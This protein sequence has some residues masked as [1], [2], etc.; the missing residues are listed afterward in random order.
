[1][2]FLREFQAFLERVVNHQMLSDPASVLLPIKMANQLQK[3]LEVLLMEQEFAVNNHL[4]KKFLTDFHPL[5]VV[6][7]EILLL[8]LV[9]QE[10]L[11]CPFFQVEFRE[12]HK[13]KLMLLILSALLLVEF[14]MEQLWQMFFHQNN[15]KLLLITS[16]ML[17]FQVLQKNLI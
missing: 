1:M 5:L 15:C 4:L 6:E 3:N 12:M 11:D 17:F 16:L 2:H 14:P 8:M 13:V 7:A 10:F 9:F